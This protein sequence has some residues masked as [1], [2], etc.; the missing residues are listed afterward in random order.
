MPCF[1]WSSGQLF[2]Q[3]CIPGAMDKDYNPN[4]KPISLCEG[5]AA[6][7]FR[8]CQRTSEDQYFS[9]SG[10]F[11]C[12]TE[13]E[14]SGSII[15]DSLIFNRGGL[16]FSW[17]SLI[18]ILIY[19]Y[20]TPSLFFLYFMEATMLCPYKP[21]KNWK[22]PPPK[23]KCSHEFKWLHSIIKQ[24]RYF[25]FLL[26]KRLTFFHVLHNLFCK[27]S[28]IEKWFLIFFLQ[29]VEILRL[30]NI[31]QYGVILMVGDNPTGPET[32]VL[33]TMSWCVKMAAEPTLMTGRT[34]T[35]V[36]FLLAPWLQLVSNAFEIVG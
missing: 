4:Q 5:C 7:G 20:E 36:R 14:S 6:G 15:V 19:N 34:V 35:L 30:W 18:D 31:W 16:I 10:A 28:A 22:P 9:S 32:D 13:S 26:N 23:K 27:W 24:N 29:R 2:V 17:V 33:M 8:K 1:V 12:L 21:V 3:S 11:R 25:H